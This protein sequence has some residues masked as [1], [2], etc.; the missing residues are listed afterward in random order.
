M[1]H[2]KCQLKCQ[3]GVALIG[4]LLLSSCLAQEAHLTHAHGTDLWEASSQV[5]LVHH[6]SMP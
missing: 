4:V 3:L 1:A 6:A 2:V 5:V